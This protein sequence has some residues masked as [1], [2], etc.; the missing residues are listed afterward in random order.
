MSNQVGWAVVGSSTFALDYVV[1]AIRSQPDCELRAI[2]SRQPGPVRDLLGDDPV[3]VT[4]RLADL[5]GLGAEVVHLVVPAQLHRSLTLE[6]LAAGCHVLVEKPM[7]VSRDEGQEM[8]AASRAARRLLA[9]GSCMAW[10]PVLAR[11]GDLLRQGVL[12]PVWHAGISIAFD[13]GAHRGWRNLTSTADGGGALHDLGSH[14][15]DAAIRL[16]GDVAEVTASLRT[17]LPGHVSDDLASLM[18]GHVSGVTS[19]LEVAFNHDCNHLSVTGSAGRLSSSAWL[20]RQFAGDLQRHPGQ[21]GAAPPGS[22]PAGVIDEMP[23]AP[24]TNVL[25]LQAGEVAAAI[26]S[27]QIPRNADVRTG[28]QVM[29]VIDAAIQSSAGQRAVS[30][31]A[32]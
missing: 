30:V 29:A 12:G 11:A 21:P 2:V 31:S 28:L 20:G 14:A 9:V 13:T 23:G 17:T 22:G 16:F 18:L 6:S 4:S 7:A 1:P 25:A 15:I 32:G 19:H 27:G 10:S 3:T 24:V 26:R 8:A 5:P